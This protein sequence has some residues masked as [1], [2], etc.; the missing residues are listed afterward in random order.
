M[1]SLQWHNP[2]RWW[3]ERSVCER[4]NYDDGERRIT[5][6]TFIGYWSLTRKTKGSVIDTV[7]RWKDREDVIISEVKNKH[8]LSTARSLKQYSVGI[9][10]PDRRVPLLAGHQPNSHQLFTPLASS[11]RQVPDFSND[12]HFGHRVTSKLFHCTGFQSAKPVTQKWQEKSIKK[13][14]KQLQLMVQCTFTESK[15]KSKA[16]SGERK[17][18]C[19][20]F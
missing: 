16:L 5:Q 2:T 4:S 8:F 13:N 9:N 14:S 3:E 1:Q 6:S 17:Q 10:L 18:S 11:I 19:S 20:G 12:L 15:A 7:Y